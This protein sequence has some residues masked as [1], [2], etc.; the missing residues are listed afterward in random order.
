[1]ICLAL[2]WSFRAWNLGASRKAKCKKVTLGMCWSFW[3]SSSEAHR[4]LEAI[5]LCLASNFQHQK[6]EVECNFFYIWHVLELPN[7]EFESSIWGRGKKICAWPTTFGA[8]RC[9]LSTKNYVRQ[10]LELL[11][12][13][14]GSFVVWPRQKILRLA[15]N[16][17]LLAPKIRGW[18]HKKLCSAIFRRV[19]EQ[20]GTRKMHLP[21]NF[22]CQK[23]EANWIF[24]HSTFHGTL[25]Q[26][27]QELHERMRQI[28]FLNLS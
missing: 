13:K 16:F 8:K 14:L 25:K 20:P 10:V 21:S 27:A 28:L 12:F 11:S 23:L 9:K 4:G 17:Q 19:E 6:L 15:S 3:A 18:T 26:H 24:L 2:S 22:Q 5:F 1:M 7:L